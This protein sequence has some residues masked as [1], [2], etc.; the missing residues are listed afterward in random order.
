MTS[1]ALPPKTPAEAATD[2]WD[3]RTQKLAALIEQAISEEPYSLD[4]FDWA[5]V[6]QQL[7]ADAAGMSLRTL[8]RLIAKPPFVR[9]RTH[10]AGTITLLLR[11][12]SEGPKTSRHIANILSKIFREKTGRRP[13]ARGYGCLIGLAK[14]WGPQA[15]VILKT[16]LNKWSDFMAGVKLEIELRMEK[17]ELLNN[18]TP[19]P[20]FFAYPH[21]PTIRLFPDV[22]MEL[23]MMEVQSSP[24]YK[25]GNWPD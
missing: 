24:N 4:G 13:N 20:M 10:V 12:G 11:L 9:E 18:K 17:D 1:K 14:I 15:P 22:A 8:Q 25:P 2:S 6:D 16:V 21:I 3:L 5:A 19:K 23:Y 7:L